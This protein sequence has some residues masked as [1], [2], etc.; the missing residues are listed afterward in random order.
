MNRLRLSVLFC[1][2]LSF[3]ASAVLAG[4]PDTIWTRYYG[5]TGQEAGLSIRQTRDRGYIF[6]GYTSSS[7]AGGRDFYVVKVADN[8]DTIWSRTLGAAL[9]DE[10]HSVRS[11]LTGDYLVA[12]FVNTGDPNAVLAVYDALGTLSWQERYGEEGEDV[13]NDVE[14][15][16]EGGFIAVGYTTSYR[17][18]GR[19]A[20]VVETDGTG[21]ASWILFFGGSED[22]EAWAV[23]PTP[24]GGYVV[25]GQS[26]SGLAA[27]GFA[28]HVRAGGD[29]S[30][31]RTYPALAAAY[32]VEVTD[33]SGYAVVGIGGFAGA[34][35]GILMTVSYT[36]L[37]A[38]ET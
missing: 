36:H 25:V 6:A 12:G 35:D 27:A 26:G 37:R 15:V 31:F 13:F 7:G 1:M 5:G 9:D 16:P 3:A 11:L 30:W 17:A 29:T 2:L 8:G 19:D 21:Q 4:P 34:Y 18:D 33:D 23:Q 22:Q 14:A 20:Y 38:H 24:D 28:A 10:A 32:D